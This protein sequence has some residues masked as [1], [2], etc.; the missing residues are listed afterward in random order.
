MGAVRRLLDQ[1]ETYRMK[2]LPDQSQHSELGV[3]V[4]SSNPFGGGEPSNPL[5]AGV[6]GD[7]NQSQTNS[8]PFGANKNDDADVMGFLGSGP[9][10]VATA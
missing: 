9:K 7:S 1:I 6:Q 3:P 8:D 2:S 10:P 5:F 4:D